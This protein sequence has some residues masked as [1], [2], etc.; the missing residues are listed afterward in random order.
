MSTLEIVYLQVV[1]DL[2]DGTIF[3]IVPWRDADSVV[4]G[5]LTMFSEQMDVLKPLLLDEGNYTYGPPVVSKLVDT[6][7]DVV[8]MQ[9]PYD[10]ESITGAVLDGDIVRLRQPYTAVETD[11]EKTHWYG[12]DIWKAGV[13]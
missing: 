8:E 7:N 4:A 9:L 11:V 10:L 2:E 12:V 13:R 5:S 3:T 1:A 6:G